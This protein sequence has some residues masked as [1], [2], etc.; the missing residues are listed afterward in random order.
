MEGVGD[1]IVSKEMT[2]ESDTLISCWCQL[3]DINPTTLLRVGP[4]PNVFWDPRFGPEIATAGQATRVSASG[5]TRV[6]TVREKA[7]ALFEGLT[8]P[9]DV[10]AAVRP[11]FYGGLS[12]H[13]TSEPGQPW[14]GFS[15]AQFV[16]PRIQVARTGQTAYLTVTHVGPDVDRRQVFADLQSHRD[17]LIDSPSVAPSE[18]PGIEEITRN[19]GRDRWR[20]QVTTALEQIANGSLTKVVLAQALTAALE[21]SLDPISTIERIDE[22]TA[23]DYR[24]LFGPTDSSTL[25]GATPERL[26]SLR[27]RT[28]LTEALAGSIGRG[29]T[30]ITD[31]SM[32]ESLQAS[33][34]DR[35]E[36][37]LVVSAI[38]EQLRPYV[39]SL[40]L[41]DRRIR[42]L[43]SVHHLETPISGLVGAE[44]HILSLVEALHPTPAVGG[45]PPEQAQ[46][47]IRNTETFER[48][49]YAAPIG[50]FDARGN[51]EFAVAIRSAVVN[52]DVATLFAG[53]GIVENS[54][55][56]TEW[57]E[58][59]LKYQPLLDAL[60]Q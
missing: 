23:N 54:N 38:Q 36:H 10:P 5:H 32:A 57:D 40:D 42:R 60:D 6:G 20:Q 21:G 15:G 47:T 43:E 59:Q 19:P 17:M 22:L 34:K 9:D 46:E 49:W 51:G 52:E 1:S 35:H 3:P 2:I 8:I 12:F 26:V 25:I 31:E 18:P 50:W 4:A 11:R 13:H 44:H 53:A 29:E 37:E 33:S 24:F 30:P 41:A 28:L 45:L 39:D 56:D 55:P 27:G 7:T 14:D 16:L 58:V 48:G